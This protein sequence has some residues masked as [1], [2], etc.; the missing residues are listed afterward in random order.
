MRPFRKGRIGIWLWGILVV[1]PS[2]ILLWNCSPEAVNVGAVLPLSG[3]YAAYGDSL[4]KGLLLAQ[5]DVNRSGGISGRRLDVLLRDSGS[6]P[7]RAAEA[8]EALIRDDRVQAAV[9][10]GTSGEA[11]AMAPVANR[12]ERVLFSPSASSPRLTAHG[13]WIFRNWPS[14]EVE[15]QTL[16]DFT[17]YSLHAVHVLVISDESAY[18]E[19]LRSVFLQRFGGPGRSVRTLLFGEGTGDAAALASRVA[20]EIGDAQVLLLAGYG[21]DL[22]P[23]LQAM[24]AAGVNLPVLSVSALSE[25][26]LLRRYAAAA[27]GVVFAR[28]AYNPA[29]KNPEVVSFVSAFTARYGHEPDIYAAHAYDALSILAEVMGSGGLRAREIRQS[30]LALR[31]YGGVAGVTS[32]DDRGDSIRPYQMCVAM[33]GRSVPLAQVLDRALVPLQKKVEELRFGR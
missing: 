17:A 31:N 9:G 1:I 27:E 7:R 6:E 2:L 13:G 15:G 32:F 12:Y 29:S 33:D 20:R 26:S 5:D 28:P 18:A 11:L 3:P 10:G 19:G 22:L 30:L 14:D 8:F 25:G 21:E 23:L 16:A 4:K 24:R